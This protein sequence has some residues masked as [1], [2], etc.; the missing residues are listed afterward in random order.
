V[1]YKGFFENAENR[2]NAQRISKAVL[3]GLVLKSNAVWINHLLIIRDN[4]P[5]LFFLL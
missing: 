5:A 2:K 3:F 1:S 4:H